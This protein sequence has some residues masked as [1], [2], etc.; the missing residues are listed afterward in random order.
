[1]KKFNLFGRQFDVL[2]IVDKK[3]FVLR[4]FVFAFAA[5][6]H[7]FVYNLFLVPMKIVTGGVSGLAIVVSNVFDISTSSFISIATI[8][9]VILAYFVLGRDKILYTVIGSIF[10]TIMIRV[11]EYIVP[12]VNVSLSSDFL[13]VILVAL[14]SGISSGFIY[15]TG[16]NTGGSD[17]IMSI[18]NKLFS[19]PIGKCNMI[20]NFIIILMGTLLFGIEKTFYAVFILLISSKFIDIVLLGIN[21][22]KMVYIKSHRWKELEKFIA[23]DLCLGVTEIGNKGG[24]FVNKEPTLLVI[25]PYEFY[26]DFKCRVLEF[27]S[28]LFMSVYDCYQISGG[29]RRRLLPF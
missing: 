10:Y 2:K 14:L 17:V 26:Y 29:F 25:L 27:D 5:F 7:A 13:A 21:D 23:G 12:M 4:F 6:V 9:L 24:I 15:R 16:F 28:S 19:I 18:I 11:T 3:N 20:V 22:S 8:L 1:M